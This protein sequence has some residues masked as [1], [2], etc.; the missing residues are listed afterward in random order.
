MSWRSGRY[1]LKPTYR[2]KEMEV[3][4]DSKAGGLHQVC[5][6]GGDAE[7]ARR[8]GFTEEVMPEV[9]LEEFRV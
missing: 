2:K 5:S 7:P 3:R 8:Q 9:G 1:S 6:Q 4:G